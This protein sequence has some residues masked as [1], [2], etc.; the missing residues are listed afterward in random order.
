MAHGNIVLFAVL[1]QS[2][3]SIRINF[4]S[5]QDPEWACLNNLPNELVYSC[6]ASND[7]YIIHLKDYYTD[8]IT[9]VT[10]QNCRDLRVVLD[11]PLLQ[12]T[13]QLQRFKVKDCERLEFVSLS[14]TSLLQTPPEVTI[15]NVREVISLPRK[16]FKSPS[17]T[18]EQKCLGAST[19]KKIRV[20]NSKIN[21][22]NT[23]AI[24]NVTGIK[25]IEFDN[26]TITDVRS[27]AIEAIMGPDSMFTITNSRIGN[28]EFKGITVQ[29][30]SAS[31]TESTFNDIIGG[32]VNITADSL[33]ITGNSFKEIRAN[34]LVLKSVNTDILQNDITRL[35]TSALN[36]I[37][38]LRKR[39]S[40]KQFNFAQNRIANIEPHSTTFDFG[41]CKTAGTAV[42]FTSNK[43][44]CQC[45]NIAFLNTISELNNMILDSTNNNT[46]LFAPCTLPVDVVKILQENEMCNLILDPRVMCL[47]Y[48]DKHNNN[49]VTTDEDVT[50]PAPTFYL[51]RQ[52]NSPNGD[53][54]AAMTA[55]NKD[56]L[57]KDTHLNMTNRT[58]IKVVF[59]SSKDFVETLRSTSSSRKRPVEET[60]SPPEEYVNRCVGAQCRNN[61][62]YDRQKALDFYKYVYAQ[63]RPPRQNDIKKKKT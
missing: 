46:C 41:S 57:L 14:T 26:V 27:Q 50:E 47:M 36:S 9:S 10:V 29:S 58:A 34:G 62:A 13:S 42:T 7:D 61:V 11:C 43:M 17:T 8:H 39:S 40:N 16:I 1:V 20:T 54:S 33:R 23:R 55:V 63:L 2:A 4:T 35:K 51:I 25:S 22:I 21:S 6:G 45:R 56:D 44:D 32:A 28:I 30:T 49:E 59:D 5:C 3:L 19:L 53:A 60:K 38:C 37:K 18:T 24:H 12:R 15:D 48:S 52:A 31:L